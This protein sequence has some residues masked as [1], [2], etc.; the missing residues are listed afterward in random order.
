V[1]VGV[2][3]DTERILLVEMEDARQHREASNIRHQ[4][5]AVLIQAMLD[6]IRRL[7]VMFHEYVEGQTY[8][9]KGKQ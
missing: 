4:Q 5:Q 3:K 9:V 1:A 8:D 2:T 6:E 7:R